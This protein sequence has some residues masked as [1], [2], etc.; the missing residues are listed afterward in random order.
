M[1]I[2]TI[3]TYP[4][5]NPQHGGQKRV[6]A[7]LEQ[8]Q[9]AGHATQHIAIHLPGVYASTSM[10]I[11]VSNKT[12]T[13]HPLAALI[14]D[15][16]LA[17]V[18]QK[19]GHAFQKF[20]RLVAEFQPDLVQVEQTFLYKTVREALNS[21]GL[22]VAMINSTHN[23]ES[24][25]KRQILEPIGIPAQ[26]ID[27]VVSDIHELEEFAAQ[28]AAWTVACTQQDAKTLKKLGAKEIIIAPNG[29]NKEVVNKQEVD[30]LK[31]RFADMG[32]RNIILYV[33]SAHPPNL[34]GYATLVGGRL[35]FFDDDTKLVV[36]GG[37]ADLIYEYAQALPNYMKT[38]YFKHVE[39]M[40][41]VEEKTLTALLDLA[42]Q[43]ILPILEGSGSNLKTA[44]AILADK[45]V[46]ATTKALHSYDDYLSLPNLVV[47]DNSDNF[48]RGM[49]L[50]LHEKKK[51]RSAEEKLL[52]SGV[53]WQNTLK[54]MVSRVA[55]V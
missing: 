34:T 20:S 19:D 3:A 15:L 10:D 23:I 31:K 27:K 29:I 41:R 40:G 33:G 49:D 55:K 18:L 38:L 45:Q 1:R 43:I 28:D 35:G 22:S 21:M 11:E 12:Y 8:Y 36:V 4:V 50:F 51:P 54:D 44:E 7:I 5:K 42:D 24:A 25:L 52:A 53:L 47:A 6:A 37:V 48:I 26:E 13:G 46:V 32:V 9:H 30:R 2:L 39:L 14:G 17:D 16:L